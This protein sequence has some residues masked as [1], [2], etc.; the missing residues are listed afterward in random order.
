MSFCSWNKGEIY[1]DHFDVGELDHESV[2]CLSQMVTFC[3]IA[4]AGHYACKCCGNPLFSSL[5]KY[6]HSTPWPAFSK[7]IKKDSIKKKEEQKGAY[8]VRKEC[9]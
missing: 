5:A 6:A 7:P 3:L 9:C 8:K 2:A 1:R 4:A